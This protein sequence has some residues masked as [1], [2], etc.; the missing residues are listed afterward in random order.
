MRAARASTP[1][2][3]AT[4]LIALSPAFHAACLPSNETAAAQVRERAAAARQSLDAVLTTL[5]TRAHVVNWGHVLEQF[6]MINTQLESLREQLGRP[7]LAAFWAHP[8]RVESA[9]AQRDLPVLLASSLLPEMAAADAEAL[10]AAA[11]VLG[12]GGGG[13][14][15]EPGLAA[16]RAAV[17][18]YNALL[19]ALFAGA[20]LPKPLAAGRAAASAASASGRGGGAP[21]ASAAAAVGPLSARHRDE[22]SRLSK[23]VAAAVEAAAAARQP[24]APPGVRP[25]VR[26]VG[27]AVSM[28]ASLPPIGQLGSA[29]Q[30]EDLRREAV[31]GAVLTGRGLKRTLPPES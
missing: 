5:A 4:L 2:S 29:R 6:G 22:V 13:G 9:D 11:E 28:L 26:P 1:R 7:A 24:P 8:S 18:R 21:P 27:P 17:A 16:T 15:G 12:G 23:A 20:A 25:G 3:R 19:E 30:A 31:L 14:G 10:A